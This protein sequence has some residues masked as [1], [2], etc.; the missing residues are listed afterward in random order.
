MPMRGRPALA[1]SP[2][3]S[4][5]GNEVQTV[6]RLIDRDLAMFRRSPPGV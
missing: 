2:N 3:S 1:A 5:I 4:A 6:N